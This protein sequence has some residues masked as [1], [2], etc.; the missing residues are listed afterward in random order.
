MKE[1][2]VN[3]NQAG[4]RLD[5]LLLK[6]L[7]KAPKSFIYKMLRK[8]NI[9]L[10]GKKAVG[11]E[12]VGQEDEIRLYLSDETM[13][14][15]SLHEEVAISKFDLDIIYE[16]KNIIIIN[17][18]IGVLSQKATKGDDSMVEYVIS[19][20]LSTNQITQDQLQSFKPAIC[21]RLDRNTG[22]LLIAGKT[23]V[24][25]QEMARVLRE[26]KLDKY[27]LCI[28]KGKLSEINKITGYLV[29]DN[30]N[31]K[32]TVLS[33]E[34]EKSDYIETQYE[35][36]A[37]NDEFTLLQVKLIT[38]KTHQIRAHLS[39][40][41]HPL[42]GDSKYGDKSIN[43]YFDKKYGL[44]AQLLHSYRYVFPRLLGTLSNLSGKKFE[45]PEPEIFTIIRSKLFTDND[46]IKSI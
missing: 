15:F 7:N 18:P 39:S 6:L 20:M 40:I 37:Y 8:K 28:V 31:N 17:K 46:Y 19:Y 26:R 29:K 5:K 44:K 22:G 12:I 2:F 4:Q 42:L 35:P 25:L 30:K 24:G 32:V 14:K 11:S 34:T 9:L 1:I 13:A 45:A 23:L 33:K 43:N 16:D 36:I 3:E 27:Y 38:G 41:G 21:N 10:N